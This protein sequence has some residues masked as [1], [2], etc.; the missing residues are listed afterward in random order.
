M[1]WT[2][3]K[4]RQPG[5]P[6]DAMTHGNVY[7]YRKGCRCDA[8]R[9][10]YSF[11]QKERRKRCK[12]GDGNFFV[13]AEVCREHILWLR[14]QGVGKRAIA[15]VCGIDKSRLIL[16][17]NGTLR[18]IAMS[19]EQ[20]IM[21]VTPE[22]HRDHAIVPADTTRRLVDEIRAAGYTLTA[23]ARMFGHKN[24]EG[25]RFYRSKRV[26]ARTEMRVKQL[27]G[28]LLRGSRPDARLERMTE[29]A[30]RMARRAA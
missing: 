23:I 3:R 20:R 15:D 2:N 7:R 5:N 12:R 9:Q 11:H 16:I 10:A 4:P 8:C 27:H 21:R 22:A 6:L 26:T 29:L 30:S 1:T 13:S 25:L 17:A 18:R 24:P 14:S 19:T 28:R